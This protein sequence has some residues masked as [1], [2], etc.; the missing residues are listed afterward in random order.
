MFYIFPGCIVEDGF[1]Y[2]YYDLPN[3]K[4]PTET[5]QECADFAASTPEGF[6]WTW[7]KN[8]KTCMVKS[9]N[10]GKTAVGHAVS[11]NSQCGKKT[12]PLWRRD[13]K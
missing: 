1:D 6:Y 2:S 11:G 8:S 13:S 12:A 3:G 5:Q 7:N 9:S 10:A 4:K